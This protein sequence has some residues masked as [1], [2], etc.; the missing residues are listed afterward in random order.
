MIPF[1][2]TIPPEQRDKNLTEKLIAENSGIL[3]WLLQG[4]TM[5]RKE[6]LSEEPDAIREANTEYRMD[7][8]SVGTF[9]VECLMINLSEDCRLPTKFLYDA[10]LKWCSRNNERAMSQKWLALRMQEKG[11]RRLATNGLR[12]WIGIAVRGECK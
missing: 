4:N 7:M 10:Y 1:N 11:F 9:I 8:D 6:G 3:N 12:V 2:V 5:R